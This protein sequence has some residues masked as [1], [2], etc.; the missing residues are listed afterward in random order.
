MEIHNFM[1]LTKSATVFVRQ[2]CLSIPG[3]SQL[4]LKVF[5]PP[6]W[7]TKSTFP[8]PGF[9]PQPQLF[10]DMWGMNQLK[11]SLAISLQLK[12]LILTRKIL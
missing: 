10:V 6:V 9:S 4:I 8:F 7:E 3:I 1:E 5:L 12:E 11:G 2:L